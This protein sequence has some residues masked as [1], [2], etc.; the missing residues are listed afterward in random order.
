MKI[1]ND[2]DDISKKR[3][4]YK[5]AIEHLNEMYKQYILDSDDTCVC[6]VDLE[7]EGNIIKEISVW[8]DK[9]K[10]IPTSHVP[11]YWIVQPYK[12]DLN[13]ENGIELLKRK[14]Q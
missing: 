10:F 14:I 12:L 7:F 9:I 1:I 11:I 3:L 6:R 8:Y 2:N 5:A 4:S 13:T